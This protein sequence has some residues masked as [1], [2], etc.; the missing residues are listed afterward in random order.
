MGR[1][2][3]PKTWDRIVEFFGDF[4][5]SRE[6][7]ENCCG[8]LCGISELNSMLVGM[9]PGIA[10]EIG[11]KKNWNRCRMSGLPVDSP[12]PLFWDC[13]NSPGFV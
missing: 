1:R 3:G 11:F 7:P 10:M 4:W 9:R 5:D 6:P 13:K 12:L 2:I 8:L